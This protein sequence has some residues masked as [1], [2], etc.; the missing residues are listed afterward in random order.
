MTELRVVS[1]NSEAD[2]KKREAE[3]ALA[4]PYKELA[5]NLLRVVRGAGSSARL[6]DQMGEVIH[7]SRE[8]YEVVGHWPAP[9]TIDNILHIKTPAEEIEEILQNDRCS[10]ED[11]DRWEDDG[12][13]AADRA[14]YKIC[15]GALQKCASQLVDQRTHER[16]TENNLYKGV[17]DLQAAR[18]TKRRR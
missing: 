11:I 6:L 8:Y 9:R 7:Q 2:F 16:T 13:M 4:W 10:Q 3:E 17:R 15:R 5:A 1:E 18:E 12:S 14:V